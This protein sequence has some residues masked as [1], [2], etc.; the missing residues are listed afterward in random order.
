M[1]RFLLIVSI[2]IVIAI[3]ITLSRSGQPRVKPIAVEESEEWM[4]VYLK[5]KKI[6]YSYSRIKGTETGYEIENRI[7]WDLY[8]M[9]ARQTINA[10]VSAHTDSGFQL[11]DFYLDFQSPAGQK[12]VKGSFRGK[13]FELSVYEGGNWRTEHRTISQPPILPEALEKLLLREGL[14]PGRKFHLYF[15]DPITQA[16]QEVSGEVIGKGTTRIGSEP[17]V[18]TR[19]D[20]T[21]AGMPA[22]LW[23]DDKNR[24]IKQETSYGM[25]LIREDRAQAL[26]EIKPEEA[27]DII[28]LFRVKA[29]QPIPNPRRVRYLKVVLT[30]LDTTGLDLEDDIQRIVATEPLTLE[31]DLNR[32]RIAHP[33]TLP[34]TKFKESLRPSLYIQ[35]D[36][37]EIIQTARKI[38]REEKSSMEAAR[39]LTNWVYQNLQKRATASIPSAREVLRDRCGDCNEHA[40]LLAAL[41]RALGIPAKIYVGLVNLGDAF[42][43]HAWNGLYLGRWIPVD[44]TYGQF[45]ADAT[46]IKLKEG[47]IEEQVKVLKVVDKITLKVVGFE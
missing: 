41:A 15:F 47:G 20:L 11:S 33:P 17:V 29:D 23:L 18:A 44:A 5:G 43:Y 26:A 30:N 31:I 9:G 34:I 6:G 32:A 12:R 35:S 40:V 2:I 22:T 37:P 42:Y 45:P 28:F 3:G 19:I 39:L 8:V 36:D 27:M 10:Y 46:H 13:S 7:K 25:V 14:T 38:V 16:V 21:V 1:R 4:G 24:M